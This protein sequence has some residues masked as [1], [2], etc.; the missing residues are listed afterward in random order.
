MRYA[1]SLYGRLGGLIQ[2]E[3]WEGWFKNRPELYRD[4]RNTRWRVY[5]GDGRFDPLKKNA[6]FAKLN[7]VALNF[8]VVGT[9]EV[10]TKYEFCV[11]WPDGW[12]LMYHWDPSGASWP[13]HPEY[14]V[15]FESP[16]DVMETNLPPF[17]GWRLPS[18]EGQPERI[19]EY[20]T[21]QILATPD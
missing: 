4:R 12:R 1:E 17:V 15:Q 13:R 10:A 14:H 20:L 16:K 5:C 9:E 21:M 8:Q 7:N 6:L 2:A 3:Q 19:L 18:A 11:A